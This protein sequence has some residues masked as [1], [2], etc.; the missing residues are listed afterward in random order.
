MYILIIITIII[1]IATIIIII[2]MIIIMTEPGHSA[3]PPVGPKPRLP[4]ATP[5]VSRTYRLCII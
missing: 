3:R 4:E 2:I 1:I 5:Q